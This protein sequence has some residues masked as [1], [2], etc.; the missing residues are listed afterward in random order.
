MKVA[1]SEER[2]EF[3]YRHP[4]PVRLWHW[5]T[6]VAVAGLL[7]TGFN[8][9]NVHPRF[10]WGEVGNEHTE[11]AAALLST[12]PGGPRPTT[13]PAPAALKVGSHQWN[14][15][16]LLGEAWDLGAD[17]M[18]FVIAIT[19][20]NW[21]F[22]AMRA[23]HFLWAWVFAVIWVCYAIYVVVS[24]RLNRFL[25]PSRSQRTLKAFIVDVLDHLRLRRATGE[26]ARDY[27]ILQKLTYLVV[28]GILIPTAI[29]SGLT[30]SNAIT[31]RFPEL[32]SVFGGRQ[33]AR[34]IHGICAALLVLFVITHI[35]QLFIA[36][37]LT[38]VRS[39]ITG[40]FR[41]RT[42]KHT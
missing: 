7:F 30:L 38:E 32:Y 2:I 26:A 28:L 25:W 12:E 4:L 1:Q 3:Q 14:V 20:D 31:A 17:G 39:M 13:H 24:G 15:T 6:A 10:Y 8:I 29:A 5:L 23:W 37:F 11:P 40:N 34:T 27:N 18:Y 19:P 36:G 42:S 22:G 41:I 21:H 33:S 9:L 16:G 35:V